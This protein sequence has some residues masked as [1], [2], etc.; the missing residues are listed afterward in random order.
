MIGP[1]VPSRIILNLTRLSNI[2][3]PVSWK[4]V[5]ALIAVAAVATVFTSLIS[6]NI[7]ALA[8]PTFVS[9]KIT[10]IRSGEWTEAMQDSAMKAQFVP[11]PQTLVDGNP[12]LKAALEGADRRYDILAKAKGY[13]TSVDQAEEFDITE[14]EANNMISVLPSGQK[15]QRVQDELVAKYYRVFIEL[16]GKYYMLTISTVGTQ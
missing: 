16:D 8:G 6:M 3:M 2:L 9:G 15:T 10:A 13:S 7:T 12:N 5:A 11:V 14:E 4:F 1:N